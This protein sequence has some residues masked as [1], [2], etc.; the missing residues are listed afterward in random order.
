[1][2]VMNDTEAR[3]IARRLRAGRHGPAA[4]RF[5][6]A[7]AE[8]WF[9]LA[10]PWTGGDGRLLVELAEGIQPEG[11]GDLWEEYADLWGLKPVFLLS[12]ALL[13]DPFSDLEAD[14]AADVPDELGQA[15]VRG[16]RWRDQAQ[17]AIA[18]LT[19]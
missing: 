15:E 2:P 6:D 11:Y 4:Q 3:A 19:G 7:F 1:M 16:Y 18:E 12:W 10:S 13:Q 14:L 17:D 8:R 9:P 5:L